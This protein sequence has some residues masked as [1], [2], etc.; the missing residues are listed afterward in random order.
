MTRWHLRGEPRPVQAEAKRLAAGRDRFAYFVEMRL[1]KSAMALDDMIDWA[2][3]TDIDVI[4]C[5]N[6]LKATWLD[7][8][9]KWTTP[10]VASNVA[11]WPQDEQKISARTVIMNFEAL[12]TSG[13][14]WLKVRL[15]G[16]KYSLTI[17][18]SHRIKNH[19]SMTTKLA[20]ALCSTATMVRILTGTPMTQNVMDYWSQL[21]AVGAIPGS[22]PY[23]FRNRYAV[24]GGHMG[25]VVVNMKNHEQ[26]RGVIDSVSFTAA[27]KDWRRASE[28]SYSVRGFEMTPKQTKAYK[29]MQEYFITMINDHEVS[30]D[31]VITQLLKLQQI[32]RGFIM[33][34][35]EVHHIFDSPSEN[36]ALRSLVATLDGHK[37]KSIIFTYY[38]ESASL[39]HAALTEAGFKPGLII[40]SPPKGLT[41]ESKR[42]FNNDEDC[43]VIVAQ[44][45]VGSTGHNLIGQPDDDAATLM[46]FYENSF[47]LGD[48]LQGEARPKDHQLPILCLDMVASPFDAKVI[49][50]LQTKRNLIEALRSKTN[51]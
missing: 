27:E 9:N 13:G 5:P 7:E 25:K 47:N 50:A 41:E 51:D 35:K 30:A 8:I 17:D 31:M 6:H 42:R 10:A 36:P 4:L 33:D 49:K 19:A 29:E 38:R 21:R 16:K 3:R 18:E 2:D 44:I 43:R 11:V 37:Q 48:R 22:N 23:A 1:G 20:I 24:M 46:M 14:K 28:M 34:G 40:G 45:S 39:A 12:A 15:K 32:S 26:L